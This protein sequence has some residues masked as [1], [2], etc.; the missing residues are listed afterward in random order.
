M[1]C[2][3]FTARGIRK[4]DW[5][6]TGFADGVR[7]ERSRA[8]NDIRRVDLCEALRRA[9]FLVNAACVAADGNTDPGSIAR[10]AEEAAGF[11]RLADRLEGKAL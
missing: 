2:E 3:F 7:V 1:A 8:L 4:A 10:I 11:T 6:A 5:N 9:A